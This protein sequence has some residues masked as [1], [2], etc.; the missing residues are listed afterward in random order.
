M[1]D[2]DLADR[3]AA[4]PQALSK[5]LKGHFELPHFFYRYRRT[6]VLTTYSAI[7]CA[8]YATAFWLRF[9]FAIDSR[10]LRVLAATLPLLVGARAFCYYAFDMGRARWRYAGTHDAMRLSA[11]TIVG[12]AIFWLLTRGFGFIPTVPRSVMVIEWGLTTYLI[13]ATWI[14]YRLLCE[15]LRF[16]RSVNGNGEHRTLIAPSSI[17]SRV[18]TPVLKARRS[19][20]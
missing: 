17:S 10:S 7:T 4:L 14:A 9:E 1:S 8:A 2:I 11:A 6:V 3:A 12:S 16:V 13:V 19:L 20:N 5:T 18:T 15:K